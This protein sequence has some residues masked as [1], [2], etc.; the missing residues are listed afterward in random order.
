MRAIARIEVGAQRRLPSSNAAS[1]RAPN[2]SASAWRSSATWSPR[3]AARRSRR[4]SRRAGP[5]PSATARPARRALPARALLVER[6]HRGREISRPERRRLAASPAEGRQAQR[7]GVLPRRRLRRRVVR[8]FDPDACG[9]RR[10]TRIRPSLNGCGGG[11]H[12]PLPASGQARGHLGLVDP[13]VDVG[14]VD[15]LLQL[16]QASASHRAAASRRLPEPNSGRC[17]AHLLRPLSN[18]ASS[19]RRRVIVASMSGRSLSAFTIVSRLATGLNVP[20]PGCAARPFARTSPIASESFFGRW[21]SFAI[22]ATSWS[23]VAPAARRAL[24]KASN[25][26]RFSARRSR[27]DQGSKQGRRRREIV[28]GAA[29]PRPRRRSGVTDRRGRVSPDLRQL[30]PRRGHRNR[31]PPRRPAVTNSRIRCPAMPEE[32]W[33][34]KYPPA[35]RG[36]MYVALVLA[37]IVVLFVFAHAFHI[38]GR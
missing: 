38:F 15:E 20:A 19:R 23:S 9:C 30:P 31:L 18:A 13:G 5:S 27:G 29:R 17:G 11:A 12:A 35:A 10:W 2:S 36:L 32:R 8:V 21:M 4:G 22:S 14:A 16:D 33:W 26:A 28:T 1:I 25:S 6:V 34:E 3:R 7:V 24:T 37:L